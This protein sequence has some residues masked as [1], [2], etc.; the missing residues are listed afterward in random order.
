MDSYA[1]SRNAKCGIALLNYVRPKQ[2]ETRGHKVVSYGDVIV[3]VI[4]TVMVMVIVMVT[5]KGR[6][7]G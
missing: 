7:V 6:S 2:D 1:R 4:V 5:K 3:I